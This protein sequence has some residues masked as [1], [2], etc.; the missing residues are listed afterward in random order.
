[1]CFCFIVMISHI[2]TF[3][4][5]GYVRVF[6]MSLN[7]SFGCFH[8]RFFC[9]CFEFRILSNFHLVYIRDEM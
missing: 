1:M 4:C 9:F 7:N 2:V 8:I 6:V 5:I 3:L